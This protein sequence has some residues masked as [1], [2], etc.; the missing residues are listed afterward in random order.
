MVYPALHLSY[1]QI[2]Q[3]DLYLLF[4]TMRGS[5]D[6]VRREFVQD[7]EQFG[8][9]SANG[10]SEAE[11]D[12]LKRRGYLTDLPAEQELGQAATILNVLSR[13]V[14]PLVE[15]TLDLAESSSESVDL[16]DKLFSLA[17]SIAGEHG[18]I[19]VHPE[20]PPASI[21]E[22]VMSR[23]LDQA[24]LHH[25]TVVPRLTIAAFPAL[26]PWLKSE[27]FHQALLISD[28]ESL[29][30]D[31]ESI[32][33]NIINSFKQQVHVLWRCDVEGM[34]QEQL[35]AVLATIGRVREK[36]SFF[37]ALLISGQLAH[38]RIENFIPIDG[39]FLPYISPDNEPMIN[40]LMSLVLTPHRLNYYPF[41]ASGA[42]KLACELRSNSM[43]YKSPAGEEV[44]GEMDDIVTRVE[45]AKA[46]SIDSVTP[47]IRERASCKYSLICGCGDRTNGFVNGQQE[48]AA[49]YEQRLRQVLPLLVF[50]IQ[51][52]NT[53]AAGGNE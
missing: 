53:R 21:N 7:L 43:S 46:T 49:V 18:V 25:S 31:V 37:T 2:P 9:S 8:S 30:R 51:K 47:L 1:V 38:D 6:I 39:A 28:R 23:I 12:A 40:M 45:S 20:I 15:L 22:R 41:F 14:Q 35:A 16:V 42:H 33:N 48:C 27:N 52:R 44:T 4:Q 34:D 36:Y 5:I 32:A 24:R 29:S 13:N 26:T 3:S 17:K 10:L 11:V 50:N 19:K